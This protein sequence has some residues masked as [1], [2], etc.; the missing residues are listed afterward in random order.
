[1]GR[2]SA[3]VPGQWNSNANFGY[4]FS[5]GSRQVNSGGGVSI[6]SGAGGAPTVN[7]I[8]SQAQARYRLTLSVNI[9]NLFNRPVYGGYSGVMTSRNFLQP[10]SA[11]SVRRTT[12]NLGLTF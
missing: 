7:M 8:A 11:T 10:T 4:T 1:L 5:F 6:T 2:N 3:R 9:Q 12:V